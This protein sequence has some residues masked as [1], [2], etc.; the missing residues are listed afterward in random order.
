[1]TDS[2]NKE[3][4]KDIEQLRDKLYSEISEKDSNEHDIFYKNELLEISSELD[5]II[6]KYMKVNCK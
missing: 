3:I 5:H 1:M 2:K 4:L 6:V